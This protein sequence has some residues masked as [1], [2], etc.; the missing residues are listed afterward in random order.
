MVSQ[1]SN[2]K[3]PKS[4]DRTLP[5]HKSTHTCN[6]QR[7]TFSNDTSSSP[8]LKQ[9]QPHVT[10]MATSKIEKPSKMSRPTRHVKF[11]QDYSSHQFQWHSYHHGNKQHVESAR[12]CDEASTPSSSSTH[13]HEKTC[14][15]R[16]GHRHAS[17]HHTPHACSSSMKPQSCTPDAERQRYLELQQSL[18]V[19]FGFVMGILRGSEYM[20]QEDQRHVEKLHSNQMMSMP[21]KTALNFGNK[22]TNLNDMQ[23]PLSSNT[24]NDHIQ[25][26][27]LQPSNPFTADSNDITTVS[28]VLTNNQTTCMSTLPTKTTPHASNQNDSSKRHARTSISIRE[29]LNLNEE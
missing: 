10:T 9:H 3:P 18:A 4:E 13:M 17:K 22:E 15:Y 8:R 28:S 16:E 5:H 24:T 6:I 7:A 27:I 2:V 19:F 26:Q 12:A 14:A 21:L 20:C 29:L 23:Q 1:K 25:Q 11:Q